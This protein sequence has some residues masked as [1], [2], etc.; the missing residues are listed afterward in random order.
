[1]G[2]SQEIQAAIQK[3]LS[4]EVAEALKQYMRDAEGWKT[5][6]DSLAKNLDLKTIDNRRLEGELSTARAEL[7]RLQALADREMMIDK[8]EREQLLMIAQVEL[9]CAKERIISVER[10][11][12]IVF[13]NP[14]LVTRETDTVVLPAA[15]PGYGP[16]THFKEK[17]TTTEHQPP[18]AA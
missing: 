7:K 15:Q 1:M 11:A 10:L 13:N 3:N 12:G 5:S 6:V 9:N 8:R 16:Q 17:T 2:L 4:G 14:R 18:P